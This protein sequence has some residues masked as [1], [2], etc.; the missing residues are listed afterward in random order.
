MTVVH[1]PETIIVDKN[2]D[3]VACDGGGGALGH[4]LVWYNF[5]NAEEVECGYCDRIFKKK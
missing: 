3:Q 5:D 2:T 4:P 1:A